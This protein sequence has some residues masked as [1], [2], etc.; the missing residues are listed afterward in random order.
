V[1]ALDIAGK[2]AGGRLDQLSDIVAGARQR[3]RAQE[4]PERRVSPMGP[5][6]AGVVGGLDD[7]LAFDGDVGTAVVET[8]QLDMIVV[9]VVIFELLDAALDGGLPGQD[10][11]SGARLRRQAQLL[12]RVVD[13]SS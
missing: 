10:L 12:Q 11:L 9:L 6:N 7:A 8:D 3:R 4:Q 1:Q 2:L 13:G 5:D